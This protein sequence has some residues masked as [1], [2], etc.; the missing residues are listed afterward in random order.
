MLPDG[1]LFPVPWVPAGLV[2][3]GDPFADD[4]DARLEI[5]RARVVS[6]VR[7]DI[8]RAF[9]ARGESREEAIAHLDRV[10]TRLRAA[11]AV[12]I[13]EASRRRLAAAISRVDAAL[14]LLADAS[15]SYLAET[16][17]D[18]WAEPTDATASITE[19]WK[20][21]RDQLT[22]PASSVEDVP[23]ESASRAQIRAAL[24]A[25]R[26]GWW[27]KVPRAIDFARASLLVGNFPR[28]SAARDPGATYGAVMRLE[29]NAFHAKASRARR[30]R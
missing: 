4:D 18:P 17:A 8:L 22:P 11:F 14:V 20:G 23:D 21:V 25:E 9:E 16:A 13:R 19:A 2:I 12:Q 10:E 30:A 29:K 15:R 6:K 1:E 26:E 3:A 5:M 24:S 28:A 27:S 7:A